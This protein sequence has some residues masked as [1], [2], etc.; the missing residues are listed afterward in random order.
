M[1]D[2]FKSL[3]DTRMLAILTAHKGIVDLS[4]KDAL[5]ESDARQLKVL[6]DIVNGVE[7][8]EIKRWLASGKSK[9]PLKPDMEKAHRIAA[10]E[11]DD[12]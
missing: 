2:D 5:E 7:E 1:A 9:H 10:G 6:A 4:N 3:E 11:R 8:L 12:K